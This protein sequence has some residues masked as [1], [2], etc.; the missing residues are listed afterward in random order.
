MFKLTHKIPNTIFIAVSGGADS[1]AALDFLRKGRRVRVLHFN[2]GTEHAEEAQDC[3]ERYCKEN[4]IKISIGGLFGKECPKGSSKE[5]FWRKQRYSFFESE[6]MGSLSGNWRDSP[7][8][9]CHHLDDVVETW[10]FTSMHGEGRLIPSKR[11]NYIRPFLLTRK[12][13]FEDWCDRKDVPYVTDPSNT[14]TSFMRNYI[15]HKLMPH[16]LTVNPGIHKVIRKKII[17]SLE[18][19]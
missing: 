15:R 17:N 14:D 16:A 5:D 3:V 10:L 4:D 2:H 7:V 12:A 1:M 13:V 9:T 6:S 19:D 8:V 18:R 11:D